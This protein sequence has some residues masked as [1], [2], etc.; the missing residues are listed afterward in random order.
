MSMDIELV[1]AESARSWLRGEFFVGDR[2]ADSPEIAFKPEVVFV[3]HLGDNLA[4]AVDRVIS[5][6]ARGSSPWLVAHVANPALKKSLQARGMVVMFS[7]VI[8]WQGVQM[9]AWRMYGNEN[10]FANW[11]GRQDAA[12]LVGMT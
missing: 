9:D 3:N 10:V 2:I 8:T 4:R 5:L 11:L 7:E 12:F 1:S 6:A